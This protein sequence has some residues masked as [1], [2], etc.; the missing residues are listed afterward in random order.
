MRFDLSNVLAGQQK[1]ISFDYPLTI[2]DEFYGVAFPEP[3]N[4]HGK[5]K[6]MAGYISLEIT[7]DIKYSTFCDRCSKPIECTLEMSFERTLVKA[8]SIE[9]ED[10]EGVYLELE[11][12]GFLEADE[13]IRE[14]FVLS[15]P[16]KHLCSEDCLGLCE[17]CGADL[18]EG[19]CSCNKKGE[20]NSVWAEALKKLSENGNE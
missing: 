11:A 14:E 8:G 13:E 3:L 1:E 12:G 5:V 15:F 20:I 6:N 16:T 9:N 10:E 19:P 2:E 18:N 7:A 4:V 17:I